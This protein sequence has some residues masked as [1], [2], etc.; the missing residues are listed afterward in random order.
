MVTAI[1]GN[2]KSC[3]LKTAKVQGHDIIPGAIPEYGTFMNDIK[4]P[5]SD[6]SITKKTAWQIKRRMKKS[7]NQNNFQSEEW[8]NKYILWLTD[9]KL[10]LR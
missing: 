8:K 3:L 2:Q 4:V 10:M 1:S 9:V 6:F 5:Y 7:E